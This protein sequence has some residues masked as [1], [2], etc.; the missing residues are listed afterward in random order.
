L[1]LDAAIAELFLYDA[2]D[3]GEPGYDGDGARVPSNDVNR[4]APRHSVLSELRKLREQPT[5]QTL[6]PELMP[7]LRER[8]I[9][10][11]DDFLG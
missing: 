4:P 3:D 8:E 2:G 6:K 10:S 7:E 11:C 9:S 1:F 5:E